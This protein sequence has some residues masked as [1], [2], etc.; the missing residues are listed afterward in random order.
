[1]TFDERCA[2]DASTLRN[3]FWPL[4][5]TRASGERLTSTS[6]PPMRNAA[7]KPPSIRKSNGHR[8]YH[9]PLRLGLIQPSYSLQW[10]FGWICN[11]FSFGRR[12]QSLLTTQSFNRRD[13]QIAASTLHS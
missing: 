11:Q 2:R 1:M 7:A 8:T 9:P 4:T 3:L 12:F 13:L 5:S 6:E 10:Q